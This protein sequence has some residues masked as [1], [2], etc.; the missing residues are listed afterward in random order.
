MSE[1]WK[2]TA[3]EAVTRLK[4]KEISPLDLVEAS[5]KR[6][7]EV[8][9]SSSEEALGYHGV[10][11]RRHRVYLTRNTEYHFRDELCIAVRDRRT[12]DW[13]PGHLALR[14]ELFGSIQ[15][16]MNGALAP[17][18]GEP[19]LG[20]ALF[21]ASGG[22][23]LIT[24]PLEGIGSRRRKSRIQLGLSLFWRTFFLLV[25][26]LVG[27]TVAWLQTFRALE[28]EPRA[29]QT[30]HKMVTG[31][32]PFLLAELAAEM[33]LSGEADAIRKEVRREIGGREAIA[34]QSLTGLDFNSNPVAPFLWL[35]LPDPWLSTTFKNAAA[36]V[37]PPQACCRIGTA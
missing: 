4:K 9:H 34:R 6:M 32:I 35:K 1:L 20:E 15:F 33:V 12:G 30:A 2:M 7:A 21:F 16:F 18:P 25:L 17:S 5:A 14:R 29:I 28:Y 26:L 10:E 37:L 8:E 36:A 13:L 24:S 3:V 19:R 22:R 31:G 23:D 27:C 11:R